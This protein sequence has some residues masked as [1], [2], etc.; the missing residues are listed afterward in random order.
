MG[1]V[2]LDIWGL[3]SFYQIDTLPSYLLGLQ[4]QKQ[5]LKNRRKGLHN[6]SLYRIPNIEEQTAPVEKFFEVFFI[7]FLPTIIGI[8]SGDFVI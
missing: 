7:F 3:V 1:Q 2:P 5:A 4:G 8:L 6:L